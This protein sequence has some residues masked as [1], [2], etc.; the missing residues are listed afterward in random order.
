VNIE[1]VS[2]TCLLCSFV[3]NKNIIIM[4]TQHYK[5]SWWTAWND[6]VHY[7]FI[8]LK[9]FICYKTWTSIHKK[10]TNQYDQST[11]NQKTYIHLRKLPRHIL[12]IHIK[13]KCNLMIWQS[14]KLLMFHL[15]S[16]EISIT[17]FFKHVFSCFSVFL[18]H[19]LNLLL[20]QKPSEIWLLTFLRFFLK[21]L[22]AIV[23]LSK[24][25]LF[26][27]K[28]ILCDSRYFLLFHYWIT[29]NIIIV[30]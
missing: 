20:L 4:S 29:L 28:D 24:W 25:F 15:E 7:N 3:F 13:D 6:C 21:F 2:Q 12:L 19:H 8:G 17:Y 14:T 30:H 5:Q 26:L 16:S 9:Y 22:D 1:R 27:V 18:T 23:L 10:W 11:T